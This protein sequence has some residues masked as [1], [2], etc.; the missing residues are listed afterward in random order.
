MI[1]QSLLKDGDLDIGNNHKNRDWEAFYGGELR[2]DFQKRGVHGEVY[3][4]HAPGV[5]VLVAPLFQL[6]PLLHFASAYTGARIIMVLVAAIGSMLVW[7]IG[8]RLTDSAAAAWCGWAAVILTPTFAMQSFMVFPDGPGLLIVAAATLLLVQLS[9]GDVPGIV[10]VALTGVAIA[11]L[12]WLHTRFALIAAGF[13]AVIALRFLLPGRIPPRPQSDLTKGLDLPPVSTAPIRATRLAAF[14]IVPAI[15]VV[16]WL[17]FFKVHYGVYDPRAPYGPAPQLL[18]WIVPASLALFF[19]GQFGIAAY[20]PAVALAFA[21]WWRRTETFSRRLALELAV[22]TVVYLAAITTVRMWWAGNPATPARFLMALLPIVAVPIAAFWTRVSASTRALAVALVA[23]GAGVTATLLSVERAYFMWNEH[24]AEPMWLGWL[25]PVV[26]LARAW[27]GFFWQ[28]PRLPLHVVIWFAIGVGTWLIVKRLVANPRAAVT[29]WG[30]GTLSIVAPAGWVF[31]SSLP[32]DPARSQMSV[33]KSEGL[34]ER[35]Y[36]LGA[37]RFARLRS[38]R[39]SMVLRPEEWGAVSGPPPVLLFEDVAAARYV[40]RVT[41]TSTFPVPL[42]LYV[43]R[44]DVPFREFS[45]TGPGTFTFPFI[46]P[47]AVPRL[48]LDT[49]PE[50]R[51]ALR[52][53]LT[54]DDALPARE[55]IQMRSAGH[56]GS[57]DVM[58]LDDEVFIERG[59]D[60]RLAPGFWVRGRSAARFVLE[61][62]AT[63]PVSPLT[64]RVLLRNGGAAN[65]V[66]IE[67]GT[68]QRLCE[69]AP[70]EERDVDVPLTPGG[71]ATVR[72]ASGSGFVPATVEAN[73][74]DRRLLGV[75]IQP[76]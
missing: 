18:S 56:Y 68:F 60:G 64:V 47:S 65:T 55:A 50:A 45:V 76:R 21:G 27:P 23:I 52:A 75:W 74:T 49:A 29:V 39:D 10:P 8:W 40:A 5:A 36:A 14:V 22:I 59:S 44:S 38:L 16:L 3:S 37:G 1:T 26:N 72:V 31:T 32:L 20:A 7:R 69:M 58:F 54:V 34:G 41:S 28:E 12:P 71:R 24:T 33:V 9:R 51:A 42:R 13:G 4:I 19:D 48:V 46:V 35:V 61:P 15:S 6:L 53:E 70:G 43:G 2:P 67:S 30:I 63:G 66:T 25:S 57:M 11:T 73:S 62:S 17:W